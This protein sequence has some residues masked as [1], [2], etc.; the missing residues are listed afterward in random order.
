ME[1]GVEGRGGVAESEDEEDAGD[2]LS[3]IVC[4]ES[5]RECGGVTKACRPGQR[6]AIALIEN[7]QRSNLI[8]LSHSAGYPQFIL[9]AMM[10]LPC[11][12]RL[13]V[14]PEPRR[15]P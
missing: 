3:D 4:S 14:A 13:L 2:A 11:L 1:G 10:V 6:E 15:P 9:A 12:D 5:S 8:S 7:G